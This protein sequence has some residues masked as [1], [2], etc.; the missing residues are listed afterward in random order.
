[1]RLL[2]PVLRLLPLLLVFL[3]LCLPQSAHAEDE[4]APGAGSG[5]LELGDVAVSGF[6]GVK[7]QAES[8]K[9][10]VDPLTKTIIDPD[11][12]TLRVLDGSL[13]S[14]PLD[15][16]ERALPLRKDFTAADIGHVFGLAFDSLPADDR[17]TPGLYAAATSAFGLHITGPDLDGD[18]LPDRL[19]TGAP[20]AVF[21][22][23]LFGPAAA[24]GAGAI[25]KI[26][27]VTGASSLYAELT[28]SGPG[29]GGLAFDPASRALFVSDLDT[30]LIHQL[31]GAATGIEIGRFDH[32]A[33]GRP[34]GGKESIAD[35]GLLLDITSPSFNTTDPASWG[36][37]QAERRINAM[38][39]HGGRLYYAAAEGP[40][41]WSVGIA[42]EAGF[43]P[44]A[45]IE[46]GVTLSQPGQVTAISFDSAGRLL[47][48]VRNAV[49]NSGDFAAF[50]ASGP[51]D[52]M[53]FTPESPDDPETPS[54]WLPD[55]EFYAVGQSAE[56]RDAS[57]GLAL[58]YAYNPDG[59]IDTTVCNGSLFA[60]GDALVPLQPVHGL[61]I[62]TPDGFLPEAGAT[63]PFA[64]VALE[65]AQDQLE[66]RG[67]AG[68]VAVLANCYG[69]T[70]FPAAA[71]GE[72]G[73]PA[74]ADGAEGGAAPPLDS[75]GTGF[76]DVTDGGPL[77]PDVEDN[78]GG[79][80]GDGGGG[81]GGGGGGGGGKTKQGPFM[82]EKKGVSANCS[83][84][85]PCTWEIKVTND[86]DK[87]IPGPVT[88]QDIISKGGVPTTQLKIVGAPT[89]PWTCVASAAAGM[90][91][92]HP[93]P[94][95]PKSSIPLTLTFQ[96][97]PGALGAA[98]EIRN[99]AVL[100]I[101]APQQQGA[102][103]PASTSTDAV[104][105]KAI[106][107]PLLETCSPKS[108]ICIWSLGIKETG[109]NDNFFGDAK[110]VFTFTGNDNQPVKSEFSSFTKNIFDTCQIQGSQTLCTGKV[111]LSKGGFGSQLFEF[112]VDPSK[113]APG[114]FV[115]A[116]ADVSVVVKGQT[117]ISKAT[118]STA[119]AT[120]DVEP[121]RLAQGFAKEIKVE[122]IPNTACKPGDACDWEMKITNLTAA[123]ITNEL[124]AIFSANLGMTPFNNP[125][126][127]EKFEVVTN[128]PDT[129]CAPEPGQPT[130][131][132]CKKKVVTLAPGASIS[133]K[134]SLRIVAFG[135]TH[136]VFFDI[137]GSA[138][139]GRFD[140]Q[141]AHDTVV[142]SNNI[143]VRVPAA[144]GAQNPDAPANGA[145]DGNGVQPGTASAAAPPVPACASIPVKTNVVGGGGGKIDPA[146]QQGQLAI[147]KKAVPGSCKNNQ[148][149]SFKITIANLS[150][151]AF[152]GPVRV[153]DDLGGIE[154][155]GGGKLFPT[156]TVTA[157]APWRCSKEGQRFKCDADKIALAPKAK[158]E[159]TVVADFGVAS[160]TLKEMK[161]CANLE[162]AKVSS[163]ATQPLTSVQ[164]P[165][166]KLILAKNPAVE[167][168]SDAGGGCAFI[169]SIT[170]PGPEEFN[171]P[172][173]FTDTPTRPDGTQFLNL[174][175]ESV[176]PLIPDGAIAPISCNRVGDGFTCSTGPV[177]KAKLPAG[178]T[179]QV[180]MSFKPGPGSG[181]ASIKNCA[182][183]KGGTEP[184]CRNIPLINGPLLR[185]EKI[186]GGNTCVPFCAFAIN[187]KNVGNA[188]AIGPFVLEDKFTPGGI[189][190]NFDE[191]DGA[192]NCG[193]AN[194]GKF[195][196]ISGADV[197][198]P[199]ESIGGRVKITGVTPAPEYINCLDYDPAANGKPSPF[200]TTFP[201]R[202]VTIKDT[203][204]KQ[205]NLFIIK[206]APN[207]EGI[208]GVGECAIKSACRFTIEIGNNGSAPFVGT[209][210][211]D[212]EVTQGISLV[213]QV[214]QGFASTP[215]GLW[216]CNIMRATTG[217]ACF[218]NETTIPPGT[219]VR[220]E[221]AVLPGMNWKKN[222]ILENCAT[223]QPNP[224]D[225]D[226]SD[227]RDCASVK[228]DPFKVKVTKTGDQT[229][230][231]GTDCNFQISLFNPGPIDHIAPVTITD[232]LTGLSSA[233]IVSITPPLPCAAQ[234]TQIPFSCTSPGDH[235][236]LLGPNGEPS[237]PEIFNMVVRLPDDAS[238]GQFSNCAYASDSSG[239]ATGQSCATVTTTPPMRLKPI[240]KTAISESC[241]ETRPCEFKVSI[242][243]TLGRVMPGPIV[244]YDL[245]TIGGAPSTQV[246]LAS[247]P[248]AP[249]VCIASA[250]PGMQCSHPGPLAVNA[251][252]DLTLGLQPLPGSIGAAAEVENCAT[253]EGIR[254]GFATD[255]ASIPVKTAAPPPPQ[256]LITPLPDACKFGMIL[257]SSGL[258]A[259]PVNTKWNGKIC[260]GI[261]GFDKSAPIPAAEKP[262]P[263]GTVLNKGKC[264]NIPVQV[265]EACKRGLVRGSKTGKCVCP[266][267]TALNKGKCISI[268]AQVEEACKRGF[269]RNGKSGKCVCPAGTVLSKGKCI[270]IPVQVEQCKRGLV[271]DQ[272]SG[273]CVCPEGTILSKGKCRPPKAKVCEGDR[274]N[275]VY[276]NCCPDGYEYA[277]GKCRPPKQEEQK[278]CEGDRPNGVYPNCCPD[279]YSYARGKCRRDQQQQPDD[280]GDDSNRPAS[281]TC[282]DGSV[283]YGKYTQCPDDRPVAHDCPDGYRELKKPNKYGA[284]CEIIPVP[285]PDPVPP[286]ENHQCDPNVELCVK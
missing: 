194:N 282:P 114:S 36:L 285:G 211:I 11:G 2:K 234:P 129:V 120:N 130:Q 274:P 148:S 85:T 196:C 54:T 15:G 69:E 111:G 70:G 171:G 193:K 191:I 106:L 30:G 87:P 277:R 68:G 242:T 174:A 134:P 123:T 177:V 183:L 169:V 256:P 97:L 257:A 264:V 9:P 4:T 20:G 8:L 44:D 21:M 118:A 246:A 165:P 260:D 279:G 38:A 275:G 252:I 113:G 241:D 77:L 50:V 160:G 162:G 266:A 251:S 17:G 57:G 268:P 64:F 135:L 13:V 19:M 18:G 49:Q 230:E 185:A 46:F 214:S 154:Q 216:H 137:N 244:V 6:S 74:V 271:R 95:P 199:G 28:N 150:A 222:H 201:G 83:E 231:L 59:S 249:W 269:V 175:L 27:A 23:G 48:A 58:Q 14:A 72:P 156:A 79:G 26:D 195:V 71:A 270:E 218:S 102:V 136:P 51:A 93:G 278:F 1:M 91:C 37:T 233:Q 238:A 7:L 66:A 39:V 88:L 205:P 43:L 81:D 55:P 3:T 204:P 117:L 243:N 105:M 190:V 200:D 61:Q 263:N 45:R 221:V 168:C 31:T 103:L 90:N 99:C 198:K 180:K 86:T 250:A 161:N 29:L 273:D 262:C 267:G 192:F 16:L 65:P 166:S 207:A 187:L 32:G 206:S 178:K 98:K 52:V 245:M 189:N 258:C 210:L 67:H 109:G 140:A 125:K 131:I 122:M 121:L 158:T 272:Q 280:T 220:M 151:T 80:G 152:D 96:P 219:S 110:V 284:Y 228:L 82:V 84:T 159:F 167:Q 212:D 47:L 186:G 203:A 223:L 237:P 53:R 89:A 147:L 40:E 224:P 124:D 56:H 265:E 281:K 170:N 188:D 149:C 286:P 142:G 276:P 141:G 236:L 155:N 133:L 126:L 225:S 254:P 62:G 107:E 226:F 100:A 76:P 182:A 259:C 261:G 25:W 208:G 139:I 108:G 138:F 173:E 153:L 197:L 92:T 283:V 127:L 240:A 247:G 172:I 253:L 145:A 22:E 213:E 132:R 239:E 179:I 163:C 34:L 215:A 12:V 128:P 104:G 235:P 255:C 157:P 143:F 41:I 227:N 184:Q 115:T 63:A 112:K 232:Q 181:A 24:G 146:T 202:C 119:L 101:A 35:D 60:S 176:T 248:A 33:D 229:C 78:G 209:L 144:N 10:G 116:T 94:F 164:P 75:N 73:L 217:T 42:P 5:I